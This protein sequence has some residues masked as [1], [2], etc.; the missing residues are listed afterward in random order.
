[1]MPSSLPGLPAAVAAAVQQGA[2]FVVGRVVR[3][4][5]EGLLVSPG[6]LDTEPVLAGYA[7][8]IYQPVLGE[9]VGLINQGGAWFCLGPIAG[10]ADTPNSVSNYSFEDSEPGAFPR[11]WTLVSTAGAPT[12]ETATWKHPEFV[13]GGQVARLAASSTTTVTCSLLSAPIPVAD[14]ETWGIGAY[15]RPNAGFGANAGTIRVYASWYSSTNTADLISEESA[16]TFPLIRGH[17][18][19]LATENGASGQGSVAPGG[20]K[21]LRAKVSLSWSAISGDAVYLDR[22][23]ARRTS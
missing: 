1:M 21:Y 8:L 14:G 19:R 18:W 7:R 10:P 2:T 15:Y 23:T 13:D 9:T 4:A 22:I 17:G 12:L 20:V 11:D 6:G 16:V 3:H 5:P